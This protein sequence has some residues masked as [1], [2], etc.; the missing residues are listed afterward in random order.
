MANIGTALH[1]I[2]KAAKETTCPSRRSHL[3]WLKTKA[4]EQ[5]VQCGVARLVCIHET[6]RKGSRCVCGELWRC[7]GYCEGGEYTYTTRY[8]LYQIGD[9]T[10]HQPFNCPLSADTLPNGTWAIR[11]LPEQWMSPRETYTPEQITE[12][13]TTINTWLEGTT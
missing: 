7:D 1:I 9:R 4:I 8:L 5:A 10:F 2:N 6:E 12:A 11:R 3:Y 13:I